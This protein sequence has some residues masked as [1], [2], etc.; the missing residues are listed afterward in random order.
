MNL[1]VETVILKNLEALRLLSSSVDAAQKTQNLLLER[2]KES[3]PAPYS[4]P[5]L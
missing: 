5:S 1:L 3:S 4:T 2:L